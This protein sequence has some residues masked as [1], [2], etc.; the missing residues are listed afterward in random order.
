ML[1]HATV[2]GSK[3]TDTN[4]AD[5]DSALMDFL[6]C[7]EETQLNNSIP[8]YVRDAMRGDCAMLL[9]HMNTRET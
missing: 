3:G 1:L 2:L 9:Q 4:K 5:V 7:G 6:F 8:E